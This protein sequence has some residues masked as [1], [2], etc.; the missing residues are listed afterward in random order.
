MKNKSKLLILLLVIAMVGTVFTGCGKN[1]ME[2]NEKKDKNTGEVK[3][4]GKE[5][6]KDEYG[7]HI[8]DDS[9]TFVDGR[10]KE[11]TIKKNPE[12]VVCLFNSY[13]DIWMKS[14][15]KVVGTIES[16]EDKPVEGVEDAEIVGSLGEPSLE[17]ILSLEPDLVILNSNMKAH[18]A[19]VEPLEKSGVQVLALHYVFKDDY[20][21]FVR[22]FTALNGREDLYKENGIKVKEEIDNIIKKVPKDKEYTAL[23]MVASQKSITV[24]GANS[25]AGE[26]LQDLNVKNISDDTNKDS[27]DAKAFS[28]EKIIEEDPDFIFVQFTGS[29][30]E[31]VLERLKNEVELNPAWSSLTAVKEDRYIFLPKDL[32]WYKANDRYPEAYMG[33]A[34]MLYPE[35][36]K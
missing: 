19:L 16:S 1:S 15:G 11:V 2:G 3:E 22:I 27:K 30:K 5:E 36:F 17:K 32:Y 7:V 6:T 8:D 33:L 21:Q 24:R 20:L 34:K 12:K 35:V 10:D 9:V 13:L 26:M 31:K 25:T 14:G 29:D 28:M 23:I 4:K 18:M